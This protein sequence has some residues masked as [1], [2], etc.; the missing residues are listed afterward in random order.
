M[1]IK[2]LKHHIYIVMSSE[3]VMLYQG[4]L[5]GCKRYVDINSKNLKT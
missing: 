3:G 2:Q 1:R 5:F 4:S